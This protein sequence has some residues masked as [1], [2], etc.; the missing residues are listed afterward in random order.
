MASSTVRSSVKLS[1][2]S[3]TNP[4]ESSVLV[5]NAASV[6]LP[7]SN[8][9]AELR[10]NSNAIFNNCVSSNIVVTEA[11]MPLLRRSEHPRVIFTSS[12]R[13]SLG[14]TASDELP[15][16]RLAN[17]CISKAALNMLVLQLKLAEEANES[18]MPKITYW[19][20]SPGHTKTGF[21]G[22]RGTKDPLQSAAAYVKL[23]ESDTGVCK[24]GTFWEFENGQFREVPW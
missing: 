16:T 21:N 17:Y 13:G 3:F 24:S 12:A 19:S 10:G 2:T 22:Y 6:S 4:Y 9:L 7:T 8:S 18:A 14:R 5:N 23:L 20:V 15:P 1:C 11:F